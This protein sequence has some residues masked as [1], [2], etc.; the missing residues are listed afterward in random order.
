MKINLP[1]GPKPRLILAHLNAEALKTGSPEIRVEDSF[2]AFVR[3]I[4]NYR[5]NGHQIRTF[6]T[7]LGNLSG[8]IIRMVMSNEKHSLQVD[9]KVVSSFDLWFQE[10]TQQRVLWPSSVQLSHEYFTNL[11][12]HAVPLPTPEPNWPSTPPPGSRARYSA[13]PASSP[14]PRKSHRHSFL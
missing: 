5:P 14:G 6:K 3:R 13:G 9:S 10:N 12:S 2:T 4:Q 8:A 11:Q 1:F 7:H